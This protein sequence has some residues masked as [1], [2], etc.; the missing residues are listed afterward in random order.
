MTEGL[1]PQEIIDWLIANDNPSQG[2]NITDRQY[3]IVDLTM[4][5]LG[6]LPIL[7]QIIL[8]SR[9]KEQDLTMPSKETYLFLKTS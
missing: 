5:V 3:G 1:T 9:V 7:E 2:G 4:G 6:L 8:M